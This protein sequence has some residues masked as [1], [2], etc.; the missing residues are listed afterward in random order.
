MN[1]IPTIQSRNIDFKTFLTHFNAVRV[2]LVGI[3]EHSFLCDVGISAVIFLQGL[4]FK[5]HYISSILVKCPLQV[6]RTNFWFVV[7][8]CNIKIPHDVY[9]SIKQYLNH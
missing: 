8:L 5:H 2:Y 1:D 9:H 6:L 7:G 3:I 4:Q